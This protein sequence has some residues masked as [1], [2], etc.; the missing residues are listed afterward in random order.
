MTRELDWP[1]KQVFTL[2]ETTLNEL[3]ARIE[4]AER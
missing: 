2:P 4:G 1:N 3:A